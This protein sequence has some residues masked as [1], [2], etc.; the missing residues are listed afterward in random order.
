MILAI[1]ADL[2]ERRGAELLFHSG[3]SAG[4]SVFLYTF[5]AMLM[6]KQEV[7]P[8]A[9]LLGN[10]D[11][12]DGRFDFYRWS[13]PFFDTPKEV[14][15]YI[16]SLGLEGKTLRRIDSIGSVDAPDE[17][18]L[19]D[20]LRAAG[21]EPADDYPFIDDIPV[22]HRVELCEPVRFVFTD[23]TVLEFMPTQK[24]GARVGVN[25]IP[26]HITDGLN[27][28]DF[29]TA[30][31]FQEAEGKCFQR[32]EIDEVETVICTTPADSDF[33]VTTRKEYFYHFK[34]EH[35]HTV[36]LV[37]DGRSRY[38]VEYR[39]S[40]N[41]IEIP[42]QRARAA[43]K[44]VDQV[45]IENGAARGGVFQIMAVD[46]HTYEAARWT[47][48]DRYSISVCDLYLSEF[49][50]KP[51]LRYFDPSVQQ[52]ALGDDEG[53]DWYWENLYTF[54]AM[55]QLLADVRRT[56]SLLLN[57][58]DHPS[59]A[60]LLSDFFWWRYTNKQRSELT[61]EEIRA[62]QKQ[63]IPCAVD[64]YDRFCTQIENMMRLP[65]RNAILFSGP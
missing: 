23:G 65:G 26:A 37:S 58:P 39:Q 41:E 11:F 43:L 15:R 57:D 20:R 42:Y 1:F 10:D 40:G 4:T 38:R 14:V 27:R 44:K 59:L 29:D 51:L 3:S 36:T 33:P 56:R 16:S 32:F 61:E 34:M 24:G 13:A 48:A 35:L 62:L 64:F 47:E 6:K 7:H 60:P 19:R 31:F 46:T 12:A 18:L 8:M 50:E 17:Y 52:R 25:T 63:R 49:L 45:K 30:Q 5:H 22:P 55:E 53:F 54:E 9:Y 21:I 28:C 2:P